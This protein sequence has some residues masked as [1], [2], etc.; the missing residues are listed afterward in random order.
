M[1][2]KRITSRLAGILLM[3]IWVGNVA[4]AGVIPFGGLTKDDSIPFSNIVD[5]SGFEWLN[6]SRTLNFNYTQTSSK[7]NDINDEFYGFRFATATDYKRLL[8]EADCSF[9]NGC[10]KGAISG[11]QP[12]PWKDAGLNVTPQLRAYFDGVHEIGI[13][14]TGT[15]DY[16]LLNDAGVAITNNYTLS[17]RGD[18][19]AL[20]YP[21]GYDENLFSQ[22][23]LISTAPATPLTTTAVP[24]PSTLA[25][26]VLGMMGLASRR[27]KKLS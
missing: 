24:E 11:D 21:S 16:S 19:N 3:F 8:I 15:S 1:G 4:N 23:L 6:L 10:T 13:S 14:H 22:F 25:I 27:F 20:A 9:A 5:A 12:A 17:R 2:L 7:I 18:I 26:F